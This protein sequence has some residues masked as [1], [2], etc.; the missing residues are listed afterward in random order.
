MRSSIV[1]LLLECLQVP[2][3]L[4]QPPQGFHVGCLHAEARSLMSPFCASLSTTSFGGSVQY[5]V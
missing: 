4:L 1:T 5:V 3:I 2:G